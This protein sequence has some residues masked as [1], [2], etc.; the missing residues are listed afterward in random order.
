MLDQT[1]V[2]RQDFDHDF[3]PHEILR[4]SGGPSRSLFNLKRHSPFEQTFRNIDDKLWKDV[5]CSSE[6]DYVE[7]PSWI[8]FLKY[9]NDWKKIE[10]MP[11]S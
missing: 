9:L 4:K 3:G 5:G 8:L 10:K 6:L 7:Q 11:P 2:T 1:T